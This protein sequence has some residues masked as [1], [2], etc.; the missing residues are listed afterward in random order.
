WVIWSQLPPEALD[1]LDI[2]RGSGAGPYGSGALTG[3]IML[4]E[5]EAGAVLDISAAERGGARFAGAGSTRWG[6]LT[7]TATGLYDRTDG[8]VPV[9]GPARGAADTPLDL[10]AV[11][12]AV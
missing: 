2:V 1:G 11:S 9:R 3:V 4:R 7:L 12:A 10:E 5:R 6:G 8:Y